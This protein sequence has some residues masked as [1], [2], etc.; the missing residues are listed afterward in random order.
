MLLKIKECGLLTIDYKVSIHLL[1]LIT[2]WTIDN[3]EAMAPIKTMRTTTRQRAARTPGPANKRTDHQLQTS[4]LVAKSGNADFLQR[5]GTSGIPAGFPGIPNVP[6]FFLK[7]RRN[8]GISIPVP[9]P[10]V[11]CSGQEHLQWTPSVK[12]TLPCFL[13]YYWCNHG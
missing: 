3:L 2:L 6:V 5:L 13:T 8:G 11:P 7:I 9:V 4:N 10:D 12:S 1:S